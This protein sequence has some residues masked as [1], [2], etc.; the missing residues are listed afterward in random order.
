MAQ[1]DESHLTSMTDF[2]MNLID[3]AWSM[4]AM[5]LVC[6]NSMKSKCLA[7]SMDVMMLCY[8]CGCPN[9]SIHSNGS[10]R[11]P[12]VMVVAVINPSV[13]QEALGKWVVGVHLS[14]VAHFQWLTES[15]S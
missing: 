11:S 7:Q 9:L 12:A 8:Q 5:S 1:L 6:L 13:I 3:Y 4:Q 10:Y 2:A 15:L 14:S